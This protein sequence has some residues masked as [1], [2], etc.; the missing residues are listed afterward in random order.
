MKKYNDVLMVEYG[1]C[2]PG[3]LDCEEACKQRTDSGNSCIRTVALPEVNF[4]GIVKCNQCSSP[5]CSEVCPTNAIT[6]SNGVVRINEEK[7]VG[8]GLCTLACPY[9]GIY[10]DP[11]AGKSF[12][13]DMCDGQ[14]QCVE[15]CP[16][17]VLSFVTNTELIRSYFCT[18]D[19]FTQG[20]GLCAGCPI[21]TMSRFTGKV[22]GDNVVLFGTP[23]C[24]SRI[25]QG[26]GL[27]ASG[28][29]ARLI[30]KEDVK[31]ARQSP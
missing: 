29:L 27:Q 12:K 4:Y 30:T 11:V 1:R 8:C 18:E 19:L 16:Y 7:C 28:E 14:P 17:H 13:C 20:V 23:G 25:T 2:P 6:R 24:C 3:C 21:E 22:L 10:Y 26:I 15:A 5:E 31:K 9:G